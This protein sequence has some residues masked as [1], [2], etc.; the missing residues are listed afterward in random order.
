MCV[1][2]TEMGQNM[3][4][5]TFPIKSHS[6]DLKKKLTDWLFQDYLLN[7]LSRA[8]HFLPRILKLHRSLECPEEPQEFKFEFGLYSPSLYPPS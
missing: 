8:Y 5:V 3:G 6:N 2:D 7:I 4:I 1:E